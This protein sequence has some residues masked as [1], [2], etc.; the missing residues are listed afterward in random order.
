MLIFY[1]MKHFLSPFQI[2]G[3]LV[4]TELEKPSESTGRELSLLMNSSEAMGPIY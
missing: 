3:F 4:T 2:H 1:L